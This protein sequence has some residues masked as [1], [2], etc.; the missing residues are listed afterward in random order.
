MRMDNVKPEVRDPLHEP[1]EGGLVGQ[2]RTEGRRA[3]TYGDLA[4]IEFCAQHGTR[5]ASE[6]DLVGLRYHERYVSVG[7]CMLPASL[8]V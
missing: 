4:V 7:S 3:R 6:S 8:A 2:L 1:G 5:L